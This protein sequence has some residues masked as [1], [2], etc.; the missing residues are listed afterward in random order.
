MWSDQSHSHSLCFNSFLTSSYHCLLPTWCLCLFCLFFLLLNIL[1][2]DSMFLG[3]EPS[4]EAQVVFQKPHPWRKLTP[5]TL[6]SSVSSSSTAGVR[7][8]PHLPPPC[9]NFCLVWSCAGFALLSPDN[10]LLEPL[11]AFG[12]LIFLRPFLWWCLCLRRRYGVDVDWELCSLLFSACWSIVSLCVNC[13]Y[14]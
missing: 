13:H 10:S 2:A 6:W 11:I 5:P 12:V 14:W 1:S 3:W 7:L 4:T 8:C 9:W